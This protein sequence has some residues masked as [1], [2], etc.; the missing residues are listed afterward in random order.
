[1]GGWT[2]DDFCVVAW[3]PLVVDM[4]TSSASAGAGGG[5]GGGN[6]GDPNEET[7][8]GC[9]CGVAGKSPWS[10]AP[11]AILALGIAARRFQRKGR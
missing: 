8:S 1:M 10:F 5:A 11:L 3:K 6:N 7:D 2:I 4:T 9:G